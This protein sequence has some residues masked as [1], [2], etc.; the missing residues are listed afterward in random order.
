MIEVG[1]IKLLTR[2]LPGHIVLSIRLLIAIYAD[3]CLVFDQ[4]TVWLT[5]SHVTPH[6]SQKLGIGW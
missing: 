4:I 2:K 6:T 1:L 5:L 3:T